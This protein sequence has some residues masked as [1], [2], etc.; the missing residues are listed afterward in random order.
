MLSYLRTNG[1]TMTKTERV[2]VGRLQDLVGELR[3]IARNNKIP[4]QTNQLNPKFG[5]AFDLCVSLLA[6]YPPRPVE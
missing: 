4:T 5:E 6:K 3:S 1:A 2:K